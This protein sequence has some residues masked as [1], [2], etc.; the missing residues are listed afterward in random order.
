MNKEKKVALAKTVIGTKFYYVILRV[1]NNNLILNT[2]YFEEE[3]NLD[4]EKSKPN[5]FSKEEMDMATKLIKAMSAKFEPEKYKDE[6]QDKIKEAIEQKIDG[7][8]I[9]KTKEAPQ[10]SVNDLMKALK[11]SLKEVKK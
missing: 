6:Y 2:L 4:E 9:T 10:K 11:M 8:E 1:E 7:K 5:N 3:I